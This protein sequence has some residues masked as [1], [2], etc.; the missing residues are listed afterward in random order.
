LVTQTYVYIF[1]REK[2]T[3]CDISSVVHINSVIVIT[4]NCEGL[5]NRNTVGKFRI[6]FKVYYTKLL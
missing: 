3:G 5:F 6:G 1:G 2:G 4:Q